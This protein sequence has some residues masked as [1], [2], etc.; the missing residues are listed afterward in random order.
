[1]AFYGK[2][3]GI[4]NS[5]TDGKVFC[6]KTIKTF[7]NLESNSFVLFRETFFKLIFSFVF[8]WGQISLVSPLLHWKWYE[9]FHLEGA[10]QQSY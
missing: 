5:L 3:H 4:E 2:S 10:I 1:M 8:F 6:E 7:S 9:V